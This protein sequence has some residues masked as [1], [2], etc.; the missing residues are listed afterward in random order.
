ML[1]IPFVS[2]N[3]DSEGLSATKFGALIEPRFAE[4]IA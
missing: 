2:F 3:P 4:P 1:P